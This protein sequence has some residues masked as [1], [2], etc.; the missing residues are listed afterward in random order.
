MNK[1]HPL[2][3]ARSVS[4]PQPHPAAPRHTPLTMRDLRQLELI[5]TGR[6]QLGLGAAVWGG[7]GRRGGRV[8]GGVPRA[9]VPRCRGALR[10]AAATRMGEA[11][12]PGA[13]GLQA[14]L[15]PAA[16]HAAGELAGVVVVDEQ[17]LHKAELQRLRGQQARGSLGFRRQEI[18]RAHV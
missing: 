17:H 16:Q 14:L 12:A 5:A 2:H 9:V 7:S 8:G 13:G 3:C 18:G 6:M 4:S 10:L 11:T 15:Q 1:I